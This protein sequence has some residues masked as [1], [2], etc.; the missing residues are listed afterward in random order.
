MMYYLPFRH[1]N[2]DEKEKKGKE[3]S[4]NELE[5]Y[6]SFKR[7]K[8]IAEQILHHGWINIPNTRT[9]HFEIEE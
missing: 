1:P 9:L 8:D 7:W 2:F 5:R 6:A 3:N 4:E